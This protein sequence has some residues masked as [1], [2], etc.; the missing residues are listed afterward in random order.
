M[1]K[2]PFLLFI[3]VMGVLISSLL[4]YIQSPSFA[5]T[6]KLVASRYLPLDAGID[7]D[8]SELSIRMFPPGFSIKNPKIKLKEHNIVKLPAGSEVTA[9]RIDFTF[10]PFQAL[11]GDIRVHQVSI[12]KGNLLLILDQLGGSKKKAKKFPFEVNWDE[13]FQV[14]AEAVALEDVD[15]KVQFVNSKDSVSAQA[16]SVRLAQWSGRG[17]LG[18]SLELQLSKIQSGFFAQVSLPQEIDEL[19]MNAHVNALGLQLETLTISNPG[20]SLTAD[21]KVKGNLLEPHQLQADGSVNLRGDFTQLFQV[22][23]PKI[24]KSHFPKGLF[25]FNGKV[26]ANLARFLETL[27]A[28]GKVN[29][30]GFRFKEWKVDSIHAE[31]EW[32]AAPGGGEILLKK[33][34]LASREIPRTGGTQPGEGGKI[35]IG[36]VRWTVGSSARLNVP[37]KIERAHIH[38]LAAPVVA[39]IYPLD[40]RLNGTA[41]LSIQPPSRE[42]GWEIQ[43]KVDGSLDQFLLDNQ[44]LNQTK[45][46]TAI[47]KI[48]KI[49]LNGE[50]LVD[51]SGLRPQGVWVS[52]PHSKLKATGK[53]DFV[54]G[55]DLLGTGTVTL[56]DIGQIAETDVRGQGTVNVHVHGPAAQ[57]IADVDAELKDAVYLNL[58][59][60]DMKGRLTWD[61]D[62][63]HLI[64][65]KVSAT[66][67][68]STYEV[69]GMLD[70][71]NADTIDLHAKVQQGNIQDFIQIF[72]NLTSNLSWFPQKLMGPMSGEVDITGGISLSKLQIIANV[73]GSNW[74]YWGERFK[75]VQLVGGYDRGKYHVSDF[76]G[77]KRNGKVFGNISFDSERKID[78]D[79]STQ[80]F[81]LSDLD[82]IALLDVPIRAKLIVQS[83]GAGKEGSVTSS[84]QVDLSSFTVRG[85]NMPSSQGS[86]KTEGGIA[87]AQSSI[88]GGQ[89][90]IDILYDFSP[91][92]QSYVHGEFKQLD[93]SP[94]L[95]LLNTKSLQ[96]KNLAGYISG[97]VNLNFHAG[98]IEKSTGM[99]NLTEYFL[100]RADTQFQLKKPVFVKVNNGS[101]DVQQL[102]VEG[103]TG[104]MALNLKSR[105]GVLDGGIRGDLDISLVEFFTPV[106]VQATGISKVDLAISGHLKEPTI[107]GNAKLDGGSVRIASLDTPFE[108]LAGNFQLNQNIVL[109]Q[110]IQADLGGGRVTSNGKITI[111]SDRYPEVDL[112]I[113]LNSP[114]V[115]V[116]PFQFVKVNGNLGVQGAE[117]PYLVEGSLN[118]ESALSREKVLNQRRSGDGFKAVQYA[119]PPTIQGDSNYS[120][121]KLKIDVEAPRG[122]QIENDLFREVQAKGKMTIVN[123]LDAPRILGKAEVIQGK[124]LFKEHVFQIQ[125]AAASFDSPTV[126]NPNFDLVASTE[127]HGVKIQM[128]AAGN[129]E[130]MKR[131]E[132][133]SN[134]A[135]QESEILSLLAMGLTSND[136]RRLNANDLSA[137]QQGE[138][139]S[140]VLHSLDFNRDLEDKTGFQVRLDESVNRLQGVSAFRPQAQ[141]DAAAAPQIT[142]RRK[143]GDRLSLSAGS[144][145]GTGTNKSNQ[146]NLDLSVDRDVSIS[147]VFNNYGTY[148]A[149]DT[150]PTQNSLG[151]DLKFQKR[152]K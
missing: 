19:Q 141:G 118:V 8:F 46:T 131:I 94:I 17:G 116:F 112:R 54:K 113:G 144:T 30:R 150:Q 64:F 101:F 88:M 21:G 77:V 25:A 60:G 22:Y 24:F 86:L 11:S 145:V 121:F 62:P 95:L 61:D 84:T 106:V 75:S 146:I 68:S 90:G 28:E 15:V 93:F 114:K 20:I 125:S 53:I 49:N 135:M 16:K 110:N 42:K 92:N 139:A 38:W 59:F 74:D 81:T 12:V 123:T 39:K 82:H 52:L 40:T 130:K 122:I 136:A 13:L 83:S 10:L 44:K 71:S 115:K 103:R 3:I 109:A 85:V 58:L 100:S 32:D 48:P 27:K 67:L 57:V 37:V 36:A 78:W 102:I 149:T 73:S 143:L 111:K 4:W 55:Y 87:R 133:T 91:K 35:D 9:E 50:V 63:S 97:L 89:A 69:E 98:Q 147:G 41:A 128:F 43:A 104:E 23:Q 137:V 80:D 6:L 142:I 14:R 56:S 5:N 47:F 151:V 76:V 120:K 134:P 105:E 107:F 140:L 138:A 119:P 31:G 79:L 65:S 108:N 1:L 70:L 129:L 117:L 152:F 66:K 33:A 18:Y 34:S 51:S 124:M 126:I 96:D 132:L 7:A 2:R 127:V 26:Q 72:K 99:M 29:V 45:K 148:G